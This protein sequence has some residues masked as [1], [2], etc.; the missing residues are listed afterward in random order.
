MWRY[1][2]NTGEQ[3]QE[4]LE[5]IGVSCVDE[6][7]T[8]IPEN[9]RLNRDL[10]L[11]EALSEMELIGHMRQLAD[12]NIST[13]EC[14]CFLGAGAY[15][16]YIPSVIQHL[17]RRQEFY[18]AYTPYQPE[19]SQGTLQAI[20]EYQTMICRLTGMDVSNAS[21]YDGATAVAEA[22]A[23]ACRSTGRTDII[24][25]K[26]VHPQSREVLKTYSRFAGR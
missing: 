22:A 18:T 16:H 4:M 24:V 23:M 10:D 8:D 17:V 1:I 7:F 11:P 2:P 15:D 9:I 26:T 13:G 12:K 25:A 6:L 21:M 3:Q 5:E 14:A 19:I 20:F